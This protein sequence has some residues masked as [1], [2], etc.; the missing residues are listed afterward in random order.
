MKKENVYLVTTGD[1]SDYHIVA[2]FNTNKKANDFIKLF[3]V[4]G[5]DAMR[6]ES[7]CL[8]PN[9]EAVENKRKPYFL[10]IDKGGRVKDLNWESSYYGFEGSSEVSFT[11]DKYWMN[12]HCFAKDEKH[13]MKIANEYR[14]QYLALNKWK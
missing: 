5:Y 13:A 3:N 12:I 6:V 1:Y 8:N 10:R 7:L 14:I 4:N 11:H 9:S 2:A